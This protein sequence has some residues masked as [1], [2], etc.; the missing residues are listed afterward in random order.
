[1]KAARPADL[2]SVDSERGA[3]IARLS[4]FWERQ[5]ARIADALDVKAIPNVADAFDY[6]AEQAALTPVLAAVM[7]RL[8]EVGAWDVLDRWN[9]DSDGWDAAMIE[10]YLAKAAETNAGRWTKAIGDR[11]ADIV[12]TDPANAVD[13]LREFLGSNGLAVALAGAFAAGAL[14]F[15]AHDA[16]TK[17]GLQRKT[18]LVTSNNPRPSHAAQNGQTVD[19]G[20]VFSNGLRWPGD[21]YG[22]ASENAN[23]TCR[24]DY[25]T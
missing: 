10:G 12:A 13:G 2:G 19:I 8:G 3:A 15:G 18:W 11:L 17:S 24:L 9:P 7:L 14:N 21:H 23:C 25:T 20:D 6:D 16:A 5:A 22:D 4:V 1:M